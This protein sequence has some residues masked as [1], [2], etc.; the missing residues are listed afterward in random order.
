MRSSLCN[1][2]R[3]IS[4]TL[5]LTTCEQNTL[6]LHVHSST[7]ITPVPGTTFEVKTLVRNHHLRVQRNDPFNNRS[8]LLPLELPNG[9]SGRD[10]KM[11]S[12][13]IADQQTSS[14]AESPTLLDCILLPPNLR[15]K[16]KFCIV[17]IRNELEEGSLSQL[18]IQSKRKEI[19]NFSYQFYFQ[20]RDDDIDLDLLVPNQVAEKII[21]VEAS[22]VV[23]DGDST[24]SSTQQ[25]AG[26][27]RLLG[28]FKDK[29]VVEAPIISIEL[30]GRKYFVL[31]DEPTAIP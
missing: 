25:R 4:L 12:N 5:S 8:A 3:N 2:L 26:Y 17:G 9:I 15:C 27:D 24:V 31:A 29:G 23:V 16:V 28:L 11:T 13:Q 22:A 18:V 21:G 19:I 14:E 1:I 30:D 20:V 6:A 7:S 10:Y